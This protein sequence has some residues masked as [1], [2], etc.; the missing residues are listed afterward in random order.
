MAQ[1]AKDSIG[2]ET[3]MVLRLRDLE[4]L[5]VQRAVAGH[6]PLGAQLAATEDMTYEYS[7]PLQCRGDSNLQLQVQVQVQLMVAGAHLGCWA[8]PATAR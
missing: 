8:Q 4:R 6:L 3:L 7:M 2:V 1:D 5:D